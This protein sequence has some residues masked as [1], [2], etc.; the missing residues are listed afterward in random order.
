MTTE[1]T[2]VYWSNRLLGSRVKLTKGS[3]EII[4]VLRSLD[5][6]DHQILVDGGGIVSL[7]RPGAWGIS[8]VKVPDVVLPQTV[9]TVLMWNPGDSK[10]ERAAV[11]VSNIW[12]YQGPSLRAG[13]YWEYTD[14]E[15]LAEIR[16]NRFK[17]L[18]PEAELVAEVL[19]RIAAYDLSKT[20]MTAAR[21]LVAAQ[22]G[23][24]L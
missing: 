16:G 9:G 17:V 1:W 7:G 3:N 23:V 8:T 2:P 11:R 18:R 14:A 10:G 15:L 22:Y 24:T 19:G 4:G 5:S 20:G 12:H 13:T 21:A 6:G